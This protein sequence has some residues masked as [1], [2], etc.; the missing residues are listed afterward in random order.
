[1]MS[2]FRVIKYSSILFFLGKYKTKL[3]RVIAVLL[4]AFITSLLY[5]DIVA[6]L[7]LKHP[8]TVI[9]ALI[10]KII[11][12]YGSLIFVLWQFKPDAEATAVPTPEVRDQGG[13]ASDVPADRLTHLNDLATKEELGNRYQKI[14]DDKKPS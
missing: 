8:D 2:L 3:F 12:V 4:F 11:I 13:E 7:E 1:M 9:Y 5:Q 10:G 6:Y 14:L